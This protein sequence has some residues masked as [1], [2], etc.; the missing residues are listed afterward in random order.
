MGRSRD[1]AGILGK[2]EAQNINNLAFLNTSSPT[3]VDSAQVKSIGLEH[4]STVDSLPISNLEAGQQAYVSGTNRLYMSNGSGWFNVALINASPSLTID[5]TGTI[6]LATDG[7]PTTITL[8]ATDS[9]TPG[10]LISFSVESDGSFAGLGTLSQDSS[11]FTI[12]PKLED[13]ATTTSATLTFKAS[14]GVSFG[15]GT[16]PLSLTFAAPT[17]TNSK[18]TTLLLTANGVGRNSTAIDNSS[19]S[20]SV[21]VT[22]LS[23]YAQMSTFSPYRP[24]GFS[25]SSAPSNTGWLSYS[26][27]SHFDFGTGDFT[28][29][30]WQY[31]EKTPVGGDQLISLNYASNPNLL[32]ETVADQRKYNIYIN[33][34]A[35]SFTEATQA[36]VSTWNHYALVRDGTGTNNIKLY[37][38]GAVSAQQTYTG[39][40]GNSTTSL[41]I[42]GGDGNTFNET[43]VTD[44]RFVKG[45]AV[46]TNTFTPNTEPLTAISGTTF[47]LSAIGGHFDDLSSNRLLAND[48]Y[49]N[50]SVIET[51]PFTPYDKVPYSQA[52]HGGSMFLGPGD[53]T[54]L[55]CTMNNIGTGNFT[56]EG[57]VY[58]DN[59]DANHTFFSADASN[60]NFD[61]YWQS[62]ST[63]FKLYMAGGSTTT[64]SI[65]GSYTPPIKRWLHLAVT[66]DGNTATMWVNGIQRG[67]V[68]DTGVGSA[69]IDGT[70]FM[71]GSYTTGGSEIHEGYISDFR[72]QQGLKYTAGQNFTPPTSPVGAAGAELYVATGSDCNIEDKSQATYGIELIGTNTLTGSTAVTKYSPASIYFSGVS[73][74]H[75]MLPNQGSYHAQDFLNL[76]DTD[77]TVEWWYYPIN[78]LDTIV[79]WDVS[80]TGLAG[81][82]MTSI[83]SSG[84]S[85]YYYARGQSPL[86]ASNIFTINTWTHCAIVKQGSNGYIFGDGVLKDTTNSMV[87][88]NSDYHWRIGDRISGAPS[89]NYPVYGYMEDFRITKG[90][91]RYTSTF[92][93]PSAAL[94][95]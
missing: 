44:M 76:E 24:N 43:F 46:Y 81:A 38:N 16:T 1:I 70:D 83:Y 29:E 65:G 89:A 32:I 84:A 21:N 45:T 86:T 11:V 87:N 67:Q 51:A 41:K 30:W 4:F 52:D 93:P 78:S 37:R 23:G 54:F 57:W 31:W 95:G 61:V 53:S 17:T 92:T 27:G 36:T 19:N 62:A 35:S 8:T 68:T 80:A 42:F 58:Y 9:D 94:E 85:L 77:W 12:T 34:T 28:V 55:T 60:Y 75:I 90:L 22:G 73:G 20:A 2:S 50:T 10:G 59:M 39:N 15:T 63:N 82:N 69:N 26:S 66:R 5:P 64:H 56:V 33:G 48:G 71:I 88:V 47:F 91:A 7:S 18:Y 6:V 14:D 74:N 40:V 72:V 79:H 3:G 25:M 49:S 13:S